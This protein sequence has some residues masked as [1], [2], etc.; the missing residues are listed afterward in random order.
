[1]TAIDDLSLSKTD[2]A[3]SNIFKAALTSNVSRLLLIFFIAAAFASGLLITGAEATSLA[4]TNAEE[5]LTRL[6]RIVAAFK[7]FMAACAAAAVLWRLGTEVALARFAPYA[8]AC[9]AMSAGPVLIWSTAYV[10][11]GALLL[12]GG[13]LANLLLLWRDPVVS[14]Q[15]AAMIASRPN[16]A[17]G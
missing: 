2:R 7:A 15:F 4:A 8:L 13:L 9:C 11:I 6:L 3:P 14:E 10:G 12:H 5:D 1:M 16:L 17:R